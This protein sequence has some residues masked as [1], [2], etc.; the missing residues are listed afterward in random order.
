MWLGFWTVEDDPSPKFHDHEAIV[1]SLSTV[2]QPME[3]MGAAAVSIAMDGVNARAE[4]REFAAVQRKL[5]SELVLRE[6]TRSLS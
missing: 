6:S 4:N 2:R 1:P 3:A 5:P